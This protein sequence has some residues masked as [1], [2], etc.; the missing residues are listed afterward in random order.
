VPVRNDEGRGLAGPSGLG[1]HPVLR[2]SAVGAY[3]ED[4]SEGK[5]TV[6]GLQVGENG[7]R[8]GGQKEE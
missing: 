1:G 6:L 2:K 8:G 4:S 5:R 7:G 3:K